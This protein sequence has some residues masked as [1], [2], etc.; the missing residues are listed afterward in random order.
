MNETKREVKMKAKAELTA[1]SLKAVIDEKHPSSMTRLAHEFGYKGSVSG[2]LAKKFRAL[3]P[4]IDELLKGTAN[5]KGNA[6]GNS[7]GK[8]EV[9]VKGKSKDVKAIKVAK[10]TTPKP[11]K[12][13]TKGATMGHVKAGEAKAGKYPNDPRNPFVRPTSAYHICFNIL[14]AHKDGL[15]KDKLLQLLGEATGKDVKHAGYDAQ[16]LLSAHPNDNG[17]SHNDSPRHRSCRPGFY[18]VRTGDNVKLMVD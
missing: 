6:N 2:S 7:E 14:A 15:A 5:A 17:L 4:G 11:D 12:K 10:A 3:L 1:E 16:V 9:A 8:T 13:S 18:V